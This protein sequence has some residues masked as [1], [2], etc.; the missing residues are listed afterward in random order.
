MQQVQSFD[1]NDAMFRF[2][3]S[4]RI[5]HRIGDHTTVIG[6]IHSKHVVI[7][8]G[9]AQLLHHGGCIKSKRRTPTAHSFESVFLEQV[10]AIVMKSVHRNHE[11]KVGIVLQFLQYESNFTCTGTFART[12][13]SRNGDPVL[14]TFRVERGTSPR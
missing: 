14:G 2:V 5:R 7:V 8:F 1:Q 12:G 4:D 10:M 9:V 11:T 6:K 13:S 3:E